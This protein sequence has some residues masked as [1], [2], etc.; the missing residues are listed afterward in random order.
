MH[1][2][3]PLPS[4]RG[5]VAVPVMAQARPVRESSVAL[6]LDAMR[7]RCVPVMAHR[8]TCRWVSVMSVM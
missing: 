3:Y 8:K 6:H 5:G 2:H 4:A 1:T 7:R